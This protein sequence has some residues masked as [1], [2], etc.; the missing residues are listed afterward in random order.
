MLLQPNSIHIF[1]RA[2]KQVWNSL[3]Q[4]IENQGDATIMIVQGQAK[5][6]DRNRGTNPSI[7]ARQ[8]WDDHP[9]PA[10]TQAERLAIEKA[11]KDPRTIVHIHNSFVGEHANDRAR[12]AEFIFELL[13][14]TYKEKGGFQTLV[15]HMHYDVD[16]QND[17]V[18]VTSYVDNDGVEHTISENNAPGGVYA[19]KIYHSAG[20]DYITVFDPHSLLHRKNL[21]NVFGDNNVHFFSDLDVIGL[22]IIEKYKQ[23]LLEGKFRIGAPDGWDK[24]D[25]PEKNLAT[26]RVKDVC[27]TIWNNMKELH[28]MYDNVENFIES[29]QFGVVKERKAQFKGAPAKPE[30]ISVHGDFDGCDCIAVDDLVDS[31]GSLTQTGKALLERGAKSFDAAVCH[32]PADESAL[33]H[34]LTSTCQIGGEEKRTIGTFITTNTMARIEGFV[35]QLSPEQKQRIVLINCGEELVKGLKNLY[36]EPNKVPVFKSSRSAPMPHMH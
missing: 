31:G 28:G 30:V 12:A 36:I 10:P 3:K 26:Q 9:G 35:D 24:K 32:G 29:V 14:E 2:G 20:V 23:S 19:P 16:G 6:Y 34:I 13:K 22:K 8:D 1:L 21:T 33:Q 17:K 5:T 7:F 18:H 11:L 4:E 27:Q 15:Y 25:D